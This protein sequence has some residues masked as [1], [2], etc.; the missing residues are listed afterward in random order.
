MPAER[1]RDATSPYL[2]QHADNPVDWWPWCD[3]A[4]A[5]ARRD[6][7]PIL[8]SIGY[9]A[10]H[11][12]HVMAHESFEDPETATLMNEL[13]VNIKVDREER[14]D[15]DHIYQ[16][17]H[18]LLARRAGGW[19]LTV[20]LSPE[21]Q[22]PFFA[23][24]YFP[25]QPR[26]GL[27]SFRD[28]LKHIA[29]AY[30]EQG[31]A[32]AEQNQAVREALAKIDDTPPSDD[33][34]DPGVLDATVNE[35][36]G[37]FDAAHGGFGGA[38][39]FPHPTTLRFLLRHGHRRGDRQAVHMASHT[40]DKMANG[41]IH[42]HLAGGFYR[43]SVD[44]QWMIPHFEKML[45]DNG[46][47][48]ALYA[49]AWQASGQ[50]PLYRHACERIADW[51]MNEMQLPDG[52]YCASL[53]AD[54]EGIEG[55]YYVWTPDEVGALLEADENRVFSARFGLDRAANL[56]GQWHLHTF[57]D[58]AQIAEAEQ[59]SPREVR[60]LLL[61][62]RNKLLTARRKR[63]PPGRD[64]KV[65]TSWNALMIK[66]MARAGRL[67]QRADWLTSARRAMGYLL[68]T[69][70]DGERVLATSR[71]G[72][73]RLNGYLDDYAY[74]IDALLELLQAQWD[75]AYI[76]QATRL[77]NYMIAHFEDREHGGFF[78]TA[79]NHETLVHRPKP[80]GDDAMPSGNGVAVEAL[81]V[82]ATLTGDAGLHAAAERAL[83]AAWPA[84]ERAAYA[85]VGLLDGL[86]HSVEPPELLVVR[87]PAG[88]LADWRSH[89][90]SD[91]RPGRSA[92]LIPDDASGL[93]PAIAAKTAPPGTIAA[94]R[95]RGN[96]CEAPF[97]DPA[98]A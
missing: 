43:Y 16:T 41:G 82:L 21:D 91:Y 79:D 11:W 89:L 6:N 33:E 49:E 92:F 27:P 56:D 13:F 74:L 5:V 61:S 62:A 2:Q 38:P 25:P 75:D 45:Y 66:G 68:D 1:L 81:Q 7:R 57:Q 59:L 96:Q 93:P 44:A 9:S 63:V 80:L 30:A 54:S 35:L 50:R 29:Q 77:A 3:E 47:L 22:T 26:H 19:P 58:T 18:Q 55:R 85:H 34:P 12:C 10:C 36:A 28:L 78:F 17:A 84:I 67:L 65:L 37:Q 98:Q 14:P 24:T 73:A 83:R 31:A 70:L 52:G 23:G 32:I 4:L 76:A 69:H 20:F 86:Q 53:D 15:L 64:E 94:Y 40:L 88:Q 48:L 95:C 97:S 60:R 42:D 8:L 87:G 90:E 72:T 51:L 46:Q 71:D 39:K